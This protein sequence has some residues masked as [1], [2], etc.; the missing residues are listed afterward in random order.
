MARTRGTKNRDTPDR[1]RRATCLCSEIQIGS[2][3][4]KPPK[5]ERALF[6]DSQADG[7]RN[8]GRT[9]RRWVAG[10]GMSDVDFH[11]I[12]QAAI[13]L[14]W[15]DELRAAEAGFSAKFAGQAKRSTREATEL[16]REKLEE[17]RAFN[18]AKEHLL[19]ALDHFT[20]ICT[21][22]KHSQPVDAG[23]RDLKLLKDERKK[24]DKHDRELL[25]RMEQETVFAPLPDPQVLH[26]QLVRVELNFPHT[27]QFPSSRPPALVRSTRHEPPE[28]GQTN[29]IM[30]DDLSTTS[31]SVAFA[32]LPKLSDKYQSMARRRRLKRLESLAAMR[33][34]AW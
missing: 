22:L 19:G 12:A 8:V 4:L 9:W 31:S 15:L 1:V 10:Q 30:D 5:L 34:P 29:P 21:S 27:G 3:G 14:G 20:T 13:K 23:E 2:G 6:R 28:L 11:K 18:Q 26:T 25:R 17:V 7:N 16:H 32:G 24:L 33:S